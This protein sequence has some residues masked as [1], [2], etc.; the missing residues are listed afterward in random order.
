MSGV[1]QPKGIRIGRYKTKRSELAAA[2]ADDDEQ[3]GAPLDEKTVKRVKAQ[4]KRIGKESRMKNPATLEVT[5]GQLELVLLERERLTGLSL[6]GTMTSDEGAVANANHRNYLKLIEALG[7]T[8]HKDPNM[9]DDWG[10]TPKEQ[11]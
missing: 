7:V 10:L 11:P 4:V 3:L 9:D 1:G 5:L 8:E 2:Q 6:S